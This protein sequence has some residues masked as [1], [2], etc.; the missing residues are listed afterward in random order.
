MNF[1]LCT[2]CNMSVD[3]HSENLR[4]NSRFLLSIV[5]ALIVKVIAQ[6]TPL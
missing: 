4:Y 1:E 5:I 6:K 2:I 3:P